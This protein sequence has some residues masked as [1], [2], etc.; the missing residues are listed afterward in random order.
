MQKIEPPDTFYLSAAVGWL[1]LGNHIEAYEELERV[2]PQLWHHPAVL[3]VKYQIFAKIKRWE[4]AHETAK[5]LVEQLPNRLV[6]WLQLAY[7]SRRR[8]GGGI[9]EAWEVLRTAAALFP[10]EPLIHYNLACHSCRLGKLSEARDELG[11][12]L[13]LARTVEM[14]SL[15]LQDPDLAPLWQVAA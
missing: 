7:A 2:S 13:E 12:A 6:H 1:E 3:Q 11:R 5:F 9:A 10:Q 15:A 14:K 8:E 4:V